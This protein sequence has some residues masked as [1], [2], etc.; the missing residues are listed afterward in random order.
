MKKAWFSARMLKG[1]L[2]SV[3]LYHKHGKGTRQS[4]GNILRSGEGSYFIWNLHIEG[5]NFL[6]TSSNSQELCVI[7][8]ANVY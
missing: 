2:L 6:G 3:Y 1:K 4:R 7:H 5:K 8:V